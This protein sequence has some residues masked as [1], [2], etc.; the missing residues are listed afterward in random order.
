MVV[1]V[2][3]DLF[4]GEVPEDTTLSYRVTNDIDEVHAVLR[5]AH[6]E[7]YAVSG[8]RCEE[9]WRQSGHRELT[10]VPAHEADTVRQLLDHGWLQASGQRQCYY[11]REGP[12][13]VEA[14]A[15]LVP[16]STRRK[17]TYWAALSTGPRAGG[18]R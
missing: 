11:H 10:A 16:A 13:D 2:N 7:G 9:V 3:T 8:R 4:G 18:P 17:L 14:S 6:I 5:I 15:V 12:D 1:P